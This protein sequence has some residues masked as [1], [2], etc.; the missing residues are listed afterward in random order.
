MSSCCQTSPDANAPPPTKVFRRV[1]IAALI[2]NAAM[3][4]VEM[5]AG[6]AAGSASL[7]AD[8]LDF[9]GDSASYAISLCVLGLSLRWR[10]GAALLKGV[11]MGLFGVF[12]IANAAW[13]AHAGTLPGAMTMGAVGTLALVANVICALLLMRFRDG[14]ANMRS[15]WLCTR[16]DAIGNLAVIA[17]GAAVFASNT[18]WPDIFVAAIMASLALSASWRVIAH[19][20]RELRQDSGLPIP[21]STDAR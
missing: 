10:S 8:A 19:A 15:V 11:S 9:L 12:V 4:V 2:I 13:H 16:N 3:F 21:L 20:L 7:Q 6:L 14:D 18:G 17:A 5:S 1:L